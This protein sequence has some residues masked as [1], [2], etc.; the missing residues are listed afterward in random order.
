MSSPNPL[1]DFLALLQTAVYA[2]Y[3]LGEGKLLITCSKSA[4]D[5]RAQEYR[6]SSCGS[7]QTPFRIGPEHV[8]R[9]L[10][11]KPSL[12]HLNTESL[13]FGYLETGLLE[14]LQRSGHGEIALEFEPGRQGNVVMIGRTT[15]SDRFLLRQS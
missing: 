7:L 15:M 6:L 12:K 4:N 8:Q 10:S 9:Y 11:Q 2:Y 14:I 13:P 1:T 3:G 5:G